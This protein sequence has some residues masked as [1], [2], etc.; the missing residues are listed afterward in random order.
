MR[1]FSAYKPF[2]IYLV[3]TVLLAGGIFYVSARNIA[4]AKKSTVTKWQL[5]LQKAGIDQSLWQSVFR[6]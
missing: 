4:E 5:M 1:K 2:L 3:F 6:A